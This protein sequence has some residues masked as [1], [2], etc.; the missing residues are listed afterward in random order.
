[1]GGCSDYDL[2][3]LFCFAPSLECPQCNTSSVV[4][5]EIIVISEVGEAAFDVEDRDRE[6]GQGCSVVLGY[7]TCLNE[8]RLSARA[9]LTTPVCAEQV[10]TLR[11]IGCSVVRCDSVGG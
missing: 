7:Y 4:V 5:E 8:E 2:E 11:N 1:M 9:I 6:N 3:E 10:R